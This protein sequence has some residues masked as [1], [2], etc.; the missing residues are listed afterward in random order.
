MIFLDKEKPTDEDYIHDLPDL[1]RIQRA[2]FIHRDIF[3]TLD[4]AAQIW[5]AYSSGLMASWLNL[6]E[7]DEDI[8]K[9]IESDDVWMG[10]DKV[11]KWIES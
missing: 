4:E 3:V 6:P 8:P 9:F 1:K 7:K 11:K 2:L 5:Q 10:W